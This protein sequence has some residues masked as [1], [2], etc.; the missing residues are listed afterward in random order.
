MLQRN[1]FKWTGYNTKELLEWGEG[2]IILD[3]FTLKIKKLRPLNKYF[4]ITDL[5]PGMYFEKS[6]L[7]VY[8][9]GYVNN[10]EKNKLF[11]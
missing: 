1:I 7:G 11:I 10:V 2:D 4:E 3:H 8:V 9:V 5:K 6:N